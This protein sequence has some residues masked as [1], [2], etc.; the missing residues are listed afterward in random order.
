MYIPYWL[1]SFDGDASIQVLG[2]NTRMW[3]TGDTR[4]YGDFFL[5][6]K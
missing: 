3:T 5:F 4:I 6:R 2:K 1:Y